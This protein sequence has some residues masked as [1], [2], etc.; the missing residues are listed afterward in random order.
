MLI[1]DNKDSIYNRKYSK[2][3][4]SKS[5]AIAKSRERQKG[6]FSLKRYALNYEKLM[7][8]QKD[9]SISNDNFNKFKL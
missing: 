6:H 8:K 1:F 7:E 9:D 3:R 5:I 4:I 2:S